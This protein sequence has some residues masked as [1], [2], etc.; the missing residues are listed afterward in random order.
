MLNSKR[1]FQGL[2]NGT[3]SAG[4]WGE[5]VNFLIRIYDT[6]RRKNKI[7]TKLES[8]KRLVAKPERN[9]IVILGL[10]EWML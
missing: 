4:S 7:I 3:L 2:D 1:G 6:A 5:K 10:P 8:P 9:L